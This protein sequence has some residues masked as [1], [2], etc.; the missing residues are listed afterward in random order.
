MLIRRVYVWYR[1][2]VVSPPSHG[3]AIAW[4]SWYTTVVTFGIAYDYSALSQDL[5]SLFVLR[6]CV[7]L[8]SPSLYYDYE[9]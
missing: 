4:N 3:L 2:L 6:V 8:C 7:S 5:N 9:S 1:D